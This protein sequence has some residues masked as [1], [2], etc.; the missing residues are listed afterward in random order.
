M[1]GMSISLV[2]VLAA[3]LALA[4]GLVVISGVN[5]VNSS[6]GNSL[7]NTSEG[8]DSTASNS[9]CVSSCRASN[10]RGG[11]DFYTCRAGC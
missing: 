6:A 11:P 5:K 1:K 9:Q 2:V 10:P 8:V 7:D 4:V 3:V